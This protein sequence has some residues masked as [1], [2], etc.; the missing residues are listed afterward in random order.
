[1]IAAALSGRWRSGGRG[2]AARTTHDLRGCG[3]LSVVAAV[4]L[5]FRV[6]RTVGALGPALRGYQI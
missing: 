1:M 4:M 3:T 2:H 6:R 5:L